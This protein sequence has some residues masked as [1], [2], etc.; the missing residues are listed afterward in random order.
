[1]IDFAGGCTR[2][3][4]LD[5]LIKSQLRRQENCHSFQLFGRLITIKTRGL[6][7]AVGTNILCPQARDQGLDIAVLP[8]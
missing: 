2:T 4:T 1:V 3:R 6:R 8:Q 7:Q 5:P